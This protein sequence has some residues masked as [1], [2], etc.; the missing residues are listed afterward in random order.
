LS[1]G[2]GRYG[3]MQRRR[4]GNYAFGLILRSDDASALNKI[5]DFVSKQLRG[6][7]VVYKVGPTSD[8]LWILVKKGGGEDGA[9]H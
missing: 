6:T 3:K 7:Q 9:S 8:F 2:G 1:I 4:F 5:L